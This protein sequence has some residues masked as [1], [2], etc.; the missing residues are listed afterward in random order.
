MRRQAD[1]SMMPSVLDQEI[2]II[3]AVQSGNGVTAANRAARNDKRDQADKRAD[4][5]SWIDHTQEL[6]A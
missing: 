1:M 6:R 4:S 5:L 2:R 3:E